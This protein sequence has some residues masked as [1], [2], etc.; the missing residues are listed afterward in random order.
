M[1]KN[2][3]LG[4]LLMGAVILGFMWLNQP[5]EEQLA[6][7]R[8]L[9]EQQ[10][11]AAQ[12]VAK[13]SDVLTV[14]SVSPAEV[15][16]I[17]NT[18]RQFGIADSVAGL[19]ELNVGDAHITLDRA[20]V[21][22]G[23]VNTPYGA[24]SVADIVA[25]KLDS[26]KPATAAA[27]VKSLREAL[28]NVAR[29]KGFAR[30]L[31]GK[32]QFVKLENEKLSLEFSTLGGVIS[33][34]SL[35]DYET[36]DSTAVSPVT[37]DGDSYSFTL[38]TAS[39]RIDTRDFY[40]QVTESNDT[41]LTMTLDLGDGASFGLRYTLRPDSYLVTMDMVQQGM[42]TVVP[43][44]M[45]T[46]DFNW[47]QRL[48]RNESGRMFEERNSALY[49][50]FMNGDVDNL[51]ES[52]DDRK[53]LNE[54]LKWVAFKNQFFSTI[55]I[56]RDNFQTA[57][58]DSEILKNNPTSLKNFSFDGVMDYSSTLANPVSMTIFIGPNSYP[59]LSG[60]DESVSPDMDL[61]L[62]KLIPLG[63]PI[64]RWINTLVVIPVFDFLGKFIHNYG[65]IILILTLFI[66]LVLFPFTYK[67]FMAQ[68]R[69]RVLAPEIKEI[70]EKYPG[71]ENAMKRQQETMALYSR[72][73]A[74]PFSGCLPMLLQMPILI[75][76]FNFFPSAIELR[77]QSFLWAHDLSAPDAIVSWSGNIP[78]ITEYFGN[79]ISLFCLLMT[80]VNLVYIHLT[81]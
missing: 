48:D 81:I 15:K 30:H 69:M 52:S 71:N 22:G 73:G 4:L 72:A 19:T 40:F 79:H 44:N 27:A 23:S 49:Y 31:T 5:S 58:V 36:Y 67:S 64:V 25:S 3:L 14:D 51:S 37:P 60:L 80:A 54:R 12:E 75:A 50:M 8:E 65:I 16:V 59:L 7:Q 6:Q 26:Y 35:K 20:G 78:L 11:K 74:S 62:T 61:H 57:T 29:Y 47:R 76:M 38:T 55:F 66:K 70:N 43:T 41:S 24:V 32:E 39:Q 21:L 9:A 13:N 28:A 17:T 56:A 42:Q 53:E 2:T 63:W 45:A 1:D 77:G 34:A 68:A 46:V 10:A 18:V 33:K